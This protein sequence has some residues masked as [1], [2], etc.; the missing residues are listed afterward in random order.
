KKK[1]AITLSKITKFIYVYNSKDLSHL[2]TYSTVEC[3][4]IFKIG[5]DTLSKYILLGKPYKNKLFTR[6]KLH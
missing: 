4:K 5:K 3:S 2:G 1:S 6:T